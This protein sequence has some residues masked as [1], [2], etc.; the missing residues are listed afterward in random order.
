[1]NHLEDNLIKFLVAMAIF[2]LVGYV[3]ACINRYRKEK[4]LAD[5]RSWFTNLLRSGAIWIRAV[6]G[7][8]VPRAF[9]D[10]SDGK[11]AQLEYD[12]VHAALEHTHALMNAEGWTR[13]KYVWRKLDCE[14]FAMKMK[15]EMVRFLADNS[16]TQH[17]IPVGLFGYTR[18]D[19]AAHVCVVAKAD[20]KDWYFDIFPEPKYLAPMD[21]STKEIESCN[22]YLF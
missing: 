22:L 19:G 1:M 21:L 9:V 16:N 8:S 2:S 13:D 15:V 7:I 3:A 4:K 5:V 11:Y 20:G 14:D 18:K 17:G 10:A 12:E 6:A